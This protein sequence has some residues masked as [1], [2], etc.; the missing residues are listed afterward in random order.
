LTTNTLGEH[1]LLPRLTDIVGAE[2]ILTQTSKG[3]QNFQK[4]MGDFESNPVA[5]VQPTDSEQISSV[6][7]IANEKRIPVVGR[8]AGTSLTGATSSKGGIVIDFSKHMN[9]ILKID[10]TNWYVHCES[11]VVI[12][13]LNEELAKYGFFFPPDPASVPWC[14]VGGVIS[15]NSGGMRTFRYGTVKNW[16]LALNVILADGTKLKLGEPLPKNR[17]GYDLVHL[18]CGSEGTLALITDAWLKIAP[19]P[20]AHGTQPVKK[21]MIFFSNWADAVNSITALRAKGIQPNLLEFLSRAAVSCVNNAFDTNVPEHDATLFMEAPIDLLPEIIETCKTQHCVESY[22]GKDVKDEERLYSARALLLL[23]IKTLGSGVY[24]EDVVVPLECLGNFLDF[25]R[26]I[27]LK[28]DLK[29]PAGGHAGDGNVHPTI[30]FDA[31][32]EDSRVRADQA[33]A[34]IIYEA[35]RLGGSVSGEHGIGSQ[36]IKFADYQLRKNN[37]EKAI[38][39]MRAIKKLWDPNNILNPGKF[40]SEEPSN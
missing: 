16:V 40:I 12:D 18:V 1:D 32:S 2:N 7:R 21:F 4:D 19:L 24:S 26:S 31:E 35:I 38:E 23:G 22:V 9:K 20:G 27:E 39:L 8:G 3:F 36:K 28:Y 30:V 10:T 29:I 25:I 11:G 17:V 34:D 14:T 6:L 13:D 33:F 15:E 37:G 5:V